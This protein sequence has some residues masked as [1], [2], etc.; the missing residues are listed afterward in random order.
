[1]ANVTLKNVYKI[2][3]G[4]K[5]KDVTAVEDFSLEIVDREFVV[6]VGPSGCGKSTTLRMVAG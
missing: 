3:P 6:F 2:Y 1:M 4:D 5:G